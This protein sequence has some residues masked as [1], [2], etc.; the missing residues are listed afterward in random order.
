M[1]N[2]FSGR[3]VPA[4]SVAD[5][6]SAESDASG[7]AEISNSAAGG[8]FDKPTPEPKAKPETK[9]ADKPL[10]FEE[11]VERANHLL[12]ANPLNREILY[13]VLKACQGRRWLLN[14]LEAYIQ[15]RP[16]A[17]TSTQPPYF[18]IQ[19]L[20]N[21]DA[22]D[23]IELDDQGGLIDPAR[24]EGL[25][26]DEKDDIVEDHAYETSKVG[27]AVIEHFSPTHR[28]MELLE[29][30]PKRYDTYCEILEFLQEKQSLDKI[31]TLLRGREILM[32]GREEGDRPMQP[33]VFIDKLAQVG[34]IVWNEGWQIS[35]EGKE[36]LE[37]IRERAS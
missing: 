23:V 21:V 28:L 16:E 6:G 10:A 34:G 32:D 29:I 33:S 9:T 13:R 7:G 22:L 5:A 24:L 12:I 36:L 30:S 15:Q 18:I 37:V 25:S 3:S 4:V 8:T 2:D 20:A 35:E 27:E 14:D 11:R 19:W 1:P 17:A 26:A 31:D